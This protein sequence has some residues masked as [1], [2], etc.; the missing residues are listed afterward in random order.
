MNRRKTPSRRVEEN[1]VND[2]RVDQVLQGTH[3]N[4]IPI[5]GGGND[6]AVVPLEMTNGEIREALLILTRV[7]T[8]HVNKGIKPRLNVVE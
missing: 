2:K 6:V 4:Q 8:T 3:G 5:V 7:F 1:N